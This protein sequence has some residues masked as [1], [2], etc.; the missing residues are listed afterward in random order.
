MSG[1]NGVG[2]AASA[3]QLNL[4][5]DNLSKG[6]VRES[7]LKHAG[8]VLTD[9]DPIIA[10]VPMLNEFSETLRRNLNKTIL[11]FS[12]QSQQDVSKAVAGVDDKLDQAAKSVADIN[13]QMADEN[14]ATHLKAVSHFTEKLTLLKRSMHRMTIWCSVFTTL[15]IFTV[16]A[17]FIILKQ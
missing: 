3:E 15:N 11:R 1:L 12:E 5:W 2:A 16:F 17:L 7:V 4:D 14:I 10:L 9:D 8:I 13:R 6:S